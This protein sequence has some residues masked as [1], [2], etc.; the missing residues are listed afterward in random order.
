MVWC[1]IVGLSVIYV[2]GHK[3]SSPRLRQSDY[4]M[5]SPGHLEWP[6]GA[7]A[8][9]AGLIASVPR[10]WEYVQSACWSEVVRGIRQYPLIGR[11]NASLP[12]Y[13]L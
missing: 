1:I 4:D 8:R 9:L 10:P 13:T 11:L 2:Q 3:P 12:K 7:L 5:G 6:S